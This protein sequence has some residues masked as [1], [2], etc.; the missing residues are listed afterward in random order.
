MLHLLSHSTYLGL[1]HIVTLQSSYLFV[2]GTYLGLE[3]VVTLQSSYLFV[4]C[5]ECLL[6]VTFGVHVA[7]TISVTCET[8]INLPQACLGGF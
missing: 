1:E 5:R 6:S 2:L 3:H 4:L 7:F 8:E